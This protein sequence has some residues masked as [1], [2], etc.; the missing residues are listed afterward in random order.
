MA[1]KQTPDRYHP[2]LKALLLL[3]G[4]ETDPNEREQCTDRLDGVQRFPERVDVYAAYFSNTITTSRRIRPSIA[5]S[6]I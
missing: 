5:A 1:K 4:R 3:R 6:P 2:F